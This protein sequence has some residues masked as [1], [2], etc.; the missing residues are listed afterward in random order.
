MSDN[1]NS[2][3]NDIFNCTRSKLNLTSLMISFVMS[4][5][6]Q[7]AEESLPRSFAPT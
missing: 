5:K 4:V 1:Y 2:F 6:G 7:D 3:P